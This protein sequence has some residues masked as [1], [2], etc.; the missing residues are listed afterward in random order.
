MKEKWY[1]TDK[2]CLQYC[3]ENSDGTFEFIEKVALNTYDGNTC[4]I[5]K[6][7]LIDIRDY[8]AKEIE[9]YISSY[10]DSLDQLKENYGKHS[11]EIIAECI[12]EEVNNPCLKTR[13]SSRNFMKKMRMHLLKT[14]LKNKRILEVFDESEIRRF[15]RSF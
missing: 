4:Y 6:K 7:A 13:V 8:T 11:N 5:V 10:Y 9:A 3:K 15:W 14:S 1:C 2:D 12:F